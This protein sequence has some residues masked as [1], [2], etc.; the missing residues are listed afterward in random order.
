MKCPSCQNVVSP[1][2]SVCNRCGQP[3]MITC[4]RC[5]QL[6]PA[7]EAA[8]RHCGWELGPAGADASLAPVAD[9]FSAQPIGESCG[10][11]KQVT[12]VFTDMSGYTRLAERLD[13]EELKEIT[14]RLYAQIATVIERYDGFIE[15]FVGDAVLAIFGT[16]HT[17]EDDP[18]RAI[19]AAREIHRCVNSLGAYQ[20]SGGPLVMHSGIST[21]LVVTGDVQFSRGIHGSSGQ[22]LNLASRLSSKARPGEILVDHDTYLLAQGFYHFHSCPPLALKGFPHPLKTYRV[23]GA[24]SRPVTVRRLSGRRCRMVGRQPQMEILED[25][26]KGL[27]AGEGRVVG[28]CGPAGC[29]K[30]RLVTEFKARLDPVCVRWYEG[31]A[32]ACTQS[33]SYAPVIELLQR[34]FGIED[35]DPPDAVREKIVTAVAGLLVPEGRDEITPFLGGLFSLDFPEAAGVSP[36]FWQSRLHTAVLAVLTAFARRGPTV[37]CLEDLHWADPSTFE[38]LRLIFNK[39]REPVLFLGVYRPQ[40]RPPFMDAIGDGGLKT[41]EIDLPLLSDGEIREMLES[42]L[43]VESVPPELQRLLQTKVDGN[44]FYLEELLNWMVETGALIPVEGQWQLASGDVGGTVP[45]TIHAVLGSRLDRLNPAA[46]AVAQCA[47]VMG[48]NFLFPILKKSLDQGGRL[49]ESL[50]QLQQLDLVRLQPGQPD[51]EYQ[52]K[53]ALVQEAVYNGML[54]RERQWLHSR[55]GRIMETHYQGRTVDVCET[56]AL[57]FS[58][59]RVTDKAFAYQLQ[60]AE[61]SLRRYALDAAH[62]YFRDA[63]ALL[64]ENADQFADVKVRKVD[65]ICRW[66]VAHYYEGAFD[67]LTTLLQT[68]LPLAESLSDPVRMGTFH[69]WLGFALFWQGRDLEASRSFLLKALALGEKT[70]DP[71][72][73]GYACAFLSKTCAELGAL[74]SGARYVAQARQ[75]VVRF[76]ADDFLAMNYLSGRGYVGWFQGDSRT[77]ADSGRQLLAYGRERSHLRLRIVGHL[78][79]GVA[80]YMTGDVE[81]GAARI[82]ESLAESEDPYYDHYGKTLLGMFSIHSG[83]YGTAVTLL[84]EVMAFSRRM[85]FDY[86]K[87]VA[88]LFLGVAY[89]AQGA[90]QRGLVQI[91]NACRL[92]RQQGRR[93]FLAMAELVLGNLFLS[94]LEKGEDRSGRATPGRMGFWLRHRL[95]APARARRHLREAIGIAE[96]T[97]ARAILGQAYLAMARLCRWDGHPNSARDYARMGIHLLEQCGAAGHLQKARATLASLT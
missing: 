94:L 43:A 26:V 88:R 6:N 74:A 29:G 57:H 19:R 51:R 62:G 5:Y 15:K 22:P 80:A 95:Q 47:A 85:N 24:R 32:F 83:E 3:L 41:V 90:P 40:G 55:I 56:L 58:R 31:Y 52:F 50:Q 72:L 21:G 2:R 73:T 70:G 87:T 25:A 14:C 49:E 35:H 78:L 92:F 17:H 10:A 65:L 79:C 46:K 81:A 44:P 53:H 96:E 68:Y 20:E 93:I 77:V 42:L 12:A 75:A 39:I 45:P 59:G 66:A 82:R 61:K 16:P 38:L 69:G 48:R 11:R 7:G 91:E 86:L 63:L 13:P 84:E 1:N 27:L 54:R 33:I 23:L 30:S 60:A 64:E 4:P 97:G 76:P 18:L 34:A 8:C 36:D 71:L 67:R 89:A 28:L 37:I 9:G